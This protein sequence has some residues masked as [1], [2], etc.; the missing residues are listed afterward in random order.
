MLLAMVPPP[1]PAPLWEIVPVPAAYRNCPVSAEWGNPDSDSGSARRASN[2]VSFVDGVLQWNGAPINE[3]RLRQYVVAASRITPRPVMIVHA[4]GMSCE[5][6]QAVTALIEGEGKCSPELCVV[7]FPYSSQNETFAPAPPPPPAPPRIAKVLQPISPGSWVT[8]DDYPA[9]AIRQQ[10]HGTT[11]FRLDVDEKGAVTKCTVTSSSGS[12][13]LDDATCTLLTARAKFGHA[14]DGQGHPIPAVYSN[15]FRWVLPEPDPKPMVSWTDT[16]RI[17]IGSGG[18]V[19][20]CTPQHF[21]PVPEWVMPG[22]DWLKSATRDELRN[23][24]GSATG[25]V[26]LVLRSELRVSG[27]ETP[28]APALSPAFKPIWGMNYRVEVQPDG[29]PAACYVDWGH[30]ETAVPAD[31]CAAEGLF[32]SGTEWH[33]MTTKNVVLTDGDPNVGEALNKLTVHL[34]HR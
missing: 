8:N 29:H 31:K 21:G 33:T 25:L 18:D 12:Q 14:E 22:C 11:G 5:K 7:D 24:R 20:S 13:I 1:E 16:L 23:V 19:I 3:T 4:H 28:A 6:L 32:E 10:Q 15:R 27:V 30:G 17:S 9:E 2:T 26:T 34:R